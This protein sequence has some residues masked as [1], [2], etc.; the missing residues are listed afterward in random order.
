MV[1]NSEGCHFR[2][3]GFSVPMFECVTVRESGRFCLFVKYHRPQV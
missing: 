1:F 2:V 3:V